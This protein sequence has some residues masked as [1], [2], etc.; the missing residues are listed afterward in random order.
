[1]CEEVS[2]GEEGAARGSFTQ[3][4]DRVLFCSFYGDLSE[5]SRWKN[6]WSSHKAG[7]SSYSH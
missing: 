7:N 2:T 5:I 4:F 3:A 1:M 6:S